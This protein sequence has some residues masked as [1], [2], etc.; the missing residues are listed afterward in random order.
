MI[1]SVFHLPLYTAVNSFSVV[2][3]CVCV[4]V[5]V[6]VCVCVC[7]VGRSGCVDAVGVA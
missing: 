2:Y 7:Q 4:C 6:Y 5:C 1:F 3:V